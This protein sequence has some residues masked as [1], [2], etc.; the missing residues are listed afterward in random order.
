MST[1]Q[2]RKQLSTRATV[3]V[4][5]GALLALIGAMGVMMGW[6]LY[7]KTFST[8]S[9]F[10]QNLF[11]L[12]TAAVLECGLFWFGFQLIKSAATW[13]ERGFAIFGGVVTLGI[14]GVNIA[15]HN[16]IARGARLDVWQANYINH[17][18]PAVITI[19]ALF[20]LIQLVLR[21]EVQ[22]AFRDAMR[23]FQTKGRLDAIEDKILDSE[24][25]DKWIS[26]N[27][28]EQIYRRAASRAG[29]DPD[30]H[31]LPSA[32]SGHALQTTTIDS[33]VHNA[34]DPSREYINGA[35][36]RP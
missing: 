25:F 7:L 28:R 5:G 15:T 17:F 10:W 21:P 30:R 3:A 8:Y 23:D 12:G 35:N 18:G 9:K 34:E 19:V 2:S 22:E 26:D 1:T 36:Q 14:I 16:A 6:S 33:T 13:A 24:E 31:A 32:P 11:A 27:F 4:T 20:V 29:Y